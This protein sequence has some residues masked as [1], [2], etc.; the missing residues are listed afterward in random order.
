LTYEN[1]DPITAIRIGRTFFLTNLQKSYLDYN[2]S[3]SLEYMNSSIYYD[4]FYLFEVYYKLVKFF[5]INQNDL[6]R[7]SFLLEKAKELLLKEINNFIQ[8]GC[9]KLNKTFDHYL[10]DE[11]ILLNL[12]DYHIQ[13]KTVTNTS[14]EINKITVLRI[15]IKGLVSI[16]SNRRIG[17]VLFCDSF[18]MS[19]SEIFNLTQDILPFKFINTTKIHISG[20]D[21]IDYDPLKI[22]RINSNIKFSEI[23]AK[24]IIFYRNE[25][26]ISYLFPDS[27]ELGYD[28]NQMF[29]YISGKFYVFDDYLMFYDNSLGHIVIDEKNLKEIAIKDEMRY[30]VILLTL[31]DPEKIPLS[32]I[33]KNEIILYIPGNNPKIKS[34]KYEMISFLK[35]RFPNKFKVFSNLKENEYDLAIRTITDNE[36]DNLNYVSNS[37][38]ITN[39]TDI[40]LEMFEYEFLSTMKS[41]KNDKLNFNQYN[42]IRESIANYESNSSDVDVE[43]DSDDRKTKIVFLFCSYF[44]NLYKFT[45]YLLDLGKI[46]STGSIKVV[47]PSLNLINDEKSFYEFY[48]KSLIEHSS[49]KIKLVLVIVFNE[50][51]VNYFLYNLVMFYE[52]FNSFDKKSFLKEYHILSICYAV[53]LKNLPKNKNKDLISRVYEISDEDLVNFILIEEDYLSKEKI[54]LRNKLISSMNSKA[55]TFNTRSFSKNKE[56]NKI[57]SE[58]NL[59]NP[60]KISFHFDILIGDIKRNRIPNKKEECF[61]KLKYKIKKELL[62]EFLNNHMN[63]P[64][65]YS[66]EKK[67]KDLLNSSEGKSKSDTIVDS[68]G[69]DIINRNYLNTDDIEQKFVEDLTEEV[70]KLRR[71]ATEPI[72][73]KVVGYV[74]FIKQKSTD[75]IIENKIYFVKSC[76]KETSIEVYE[77]KIKKISNEEIGFLLYGENLKANLAYLQDLILEF[78]GEIPE[79]KEN[80]TINNLTEAEMRNLNAVNLKREI[81]PGWKKDGAIFID[82][83]GN[84]HYSHPSNILI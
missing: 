1:F 36:N 29:N 51:K 84:I 56:V 45:K 52:K 13:G 3:Q 69:K 58:K 40:I 41:W 60:K 16:H 76:Y 53:N 64:Q 67:L 54:E 65:K 42:Y 71:G 15:E 63:I 46:Y 61:V 80:K 2:D 17:S 82:P 23:E 55:I 22:L 47:F 8:L 48:C 34:I 50:I 28:H 68:D 9:R 70:K 75:A 83:E 6:I 44:D 79:S 57:F 31:Q 78:T 39:I 10:K 25:Y 77:E 21:N 81:P 24:G 38:N 73:E 20:L 26:N 74:K 4:S 37:F 32:N 66:H 30:T 59:M 14:D 19:N 11:N 72:I 5:R 33:C 18:L 62:E 27:Q 12:S 7:K 43:L 35:M 49:Q